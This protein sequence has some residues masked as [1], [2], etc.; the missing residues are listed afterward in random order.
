MDLVFLLI[1]IASATAGSAVMRARGQSLRWPLMTIGIAVVTLVLSVLAL[2]DEGMLASLGRNR[3]ALLAGEWWRIVTPLFAQDGGWPGLIFNI[4]ALL[5]LGGFIEIALGGW[6]LV[7]TYFV[8]GLLT[9]VV[10]YTLLPGQGFAGNSIANFGVAGALAVIGVGAT[11]DLRVRVLAIVSLAAGAFL[12][13]TL[14]LHGAGYAI[15]AL[16]GVGYVLL[17]RSKDRPRISAKSVAPGSPGE[18]SAGS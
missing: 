17:T 16:I 14:N 15:G 12:L 1:V 8:S 3:D 13:V 2:F 7:V 11:S 18:S 5:V 6:M 4:V 9:E 10:A